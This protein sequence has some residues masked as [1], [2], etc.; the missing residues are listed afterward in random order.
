MLKDESQGGRSM[1]WLHHFNYLPLKLVNLQQ[2][3]PE[4][5]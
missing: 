4:D 3:Q 1:A 5:T 2:E